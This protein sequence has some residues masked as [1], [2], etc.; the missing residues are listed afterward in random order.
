M[1]IVFERVYISSVTHAFTENMV[2]VPRMRMSDDIPENAPA[3][4]KIS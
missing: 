1:P 3:N 4:L 2:P